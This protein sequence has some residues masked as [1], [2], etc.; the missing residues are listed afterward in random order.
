MALSDEAQKRIWILATNVFQSDEDFESYNSKVYLLFKVF[1]QQSKINN[2][3]LKSKIEFVK[4]VNMQKNLLP[5][6]GSSISKIRANW[7]FNPSKF[8][9]GDMFNVFKLGRFHVGFYMLDVMG[10]GFSA[11]VVS[12]TLHKLLTPGSGGILKRKKSI[13]KNSLCTSCKRALYTRFK[14]YGRSH[15]A[16]AL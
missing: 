11:A 15:C 14:K 1:E 2:C 5:P 3:N 9:S 12:T 16:C 7:V 8:G 6:N 13:Y 10:H 4:P